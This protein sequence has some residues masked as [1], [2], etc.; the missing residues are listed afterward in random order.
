MRFH[1]VIVVGGGRA[2]M[3]AA[4]EAAAGGID[5][6]LLSKVHPLRSHSGAAQGGINA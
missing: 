6:A 2:G 1:D 4:I 5:V 3:R